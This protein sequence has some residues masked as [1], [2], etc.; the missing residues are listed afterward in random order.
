MERRLQDISAGIA[1]VPP[2]S[3][4]GHGGRGRGGS[5]EEDRE[6]GS[7]VST[8]LMRVVG[9]WMRHRDLQQAL[10][11]GA[12]INDQASRV[13]A[14]SPTPPMRDAVGV[15]TLGRRR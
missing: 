2:A 10:L 11:R 4:L 13:C 3:P 9:Q 1:L 14:P 5:E 7:Q 6:R 15:G 12:A 8:K